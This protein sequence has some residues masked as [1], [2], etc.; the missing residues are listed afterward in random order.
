LIVPPYKPLSYLKG[1]HLETMIPNLLRKPKKIIAEQ[2]KINTP[3][4]DF[5]QLDLYRNG[6]KSLVILSHGLEGS[7]ARV[8]ITG[9][10]KIFLDHNMDALAWNYRGCGS[11]LNKQP[12]LYHSGATA[13]LKTVVSHAI[14]MGY[15]KIVLVGVSLGGNL[16][17]KYVGENGEKLPKEVK[18]ATAFS[19]PLDL[20]ASCRQISLPSNWMYSK[21][22]IIKLKKKIRIKHKQFPEKINL[23]KLDEVQDLKSFDDLYTGPIHGFEGADDY[24]EKCSSI[25]FLTNIQIPTLIVNAL[26]DPFLSQECYPYDLIAQNKNITFETPDHG[27]HVGFIEINEE[28]YY[29]SEKRALSFANQY[30][31]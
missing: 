2:V 9:M 8:Y 4:N 20:A 6:S 24:Y 12:V 17:L 25:N 16:T 21:R 15:E 18:L 5:L 13:D 29:W 30:L 19:T 22:F 3:D 11:E 14:S 27:G 26:N 10:A 23:S 1:K 7:S 28:G 31:D